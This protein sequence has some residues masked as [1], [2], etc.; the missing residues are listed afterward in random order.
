MKR[1][2]TRKITVGSVPIGGAGPII[3]QSMLKTDPENFRETLNRQGSLKKPAAN[4][5]GS[6]SPMRTP[7]RS[8]LS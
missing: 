8:S 6:P 5:S 2:K 1:K 7:A 4:W 3:V